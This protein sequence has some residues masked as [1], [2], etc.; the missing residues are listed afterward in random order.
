RRR[1]LL[2]VAPSDARQGEVLAELVRQRGIDRIA[3]TFTNNDYGKGL[4]DSFE[5][6]FVARGGDVAAAVPHED[7][8]ADCSAE[9][10]ALAASGAEHLLVIGYIDQGGR[11]IM[12][13]ALDLGAFAHFV[14]SDGM[15]GDSLVAAFG[16]A[17]EGSFG[18]VPGNAGP[19]AEA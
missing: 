8:K 17:L 19:E 16:D 3:L 7:G 11:Q 12:R 1:P 5:R 18:T 14:L 10:G 6:A 9:V 4:A 2:R 15:I 13:A